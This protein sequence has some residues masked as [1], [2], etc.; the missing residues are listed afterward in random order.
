MSRLLTAI[1]VSAITVTPF[2]AQA[3]DLPKVPGI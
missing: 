3:F 1:L 2:A